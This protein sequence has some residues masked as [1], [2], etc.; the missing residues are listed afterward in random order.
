[1]KRPGLEA[2]D[3]AAQEAESGRLQGAP[4]ALAPACRRQIG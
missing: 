4:P 3:R 1:M 2:G